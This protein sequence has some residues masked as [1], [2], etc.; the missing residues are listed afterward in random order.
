MNARPDSVLSHRIAAADRRI[1]SVIAWLAVFGD[2]FAV[3]HGLL[4]S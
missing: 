4:Q 2:K 1:K 3:A